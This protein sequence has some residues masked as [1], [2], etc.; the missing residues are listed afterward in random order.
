MS[1]ME[2]SFSNEFGESW[3]EQQC[4]SMLSMPSTKLVLAGLEDE[5]N[6]PSSSSVCAFAILRAVAEE[7]ELLMIA[8][9]PNR[10][11]IGVGSILLEH[12]ITEAIDAG[13]NSIFLEVRENNPAQKLYCAHGFKKIGRRAS[14]YTGHNKKKF[15]AITYK[16]PLQ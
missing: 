5:V 8:V 12:I 10:Q 6:I 16:R 1:I 4:L 11:N 7:Q 14:Y 15:D 2:R 9:D 3:N 13:I